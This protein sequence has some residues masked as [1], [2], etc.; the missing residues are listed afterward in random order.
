MGSSLSW[1]NCPFNAIDTGTSLFVPAHSP[2]TLGY[3]PAF[4][5]APPCR[6]VSPVAG[7]IVCVA[8]GIGLIDSVD[9]ALQDES[10]LGLGLAVM[11][12]RPYGSG[13]CSRLPIGIPEGETSTDIPAT[14]SV[15][16]PLD[17]RVAI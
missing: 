2:G 5:L 12:F 4:S 16:L 17:T 13:V 7:T 9:L 15:L 8:C 6:L 14:P 11:L 1:P 3:T 10:A